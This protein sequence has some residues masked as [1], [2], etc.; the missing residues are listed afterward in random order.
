MTDRD[1]E[2]FMSAELKQIA[3]P[4]ASAGAEPERVELPLSAEKVAAGFPL[5]NGG[6][7]ESSLDLNEFCI[8]HPS[9][10]YIFQVEGESLI[11]AGIQP[12]DYLIVDRSL[13]P[14][15]GDLVITSIHG[16]FTAKFFRNHPV[17]QLIPANPHFS[18]I[19]ITPDLECEITGVVV[20]SF[21]K[22]R[23]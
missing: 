12:G 11:D 23:C 9:S 18:P 3:A 21:R 13:P 19:I 22:Y 7:V 8:R 10:S 2:S 1:S 20:T 14:R 17:P 4:A 6:Y 5:P 16:E 15:N